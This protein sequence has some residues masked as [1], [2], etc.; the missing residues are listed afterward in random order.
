MNQLCGQLQK[1]ESYFKKGSRLY[2]LNVEQAFRV[3]SSSCRFR[4]SPLDLNNEEMFNEYLVKFYQVLFS[5]FKSKKDNFKINNK[6]FVMIT[7]KVAQRRNQVT[8]FV[9]LE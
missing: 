7:K 8:E 3:A 5:E 1:L 9:K 2:E 4:Q 6:F